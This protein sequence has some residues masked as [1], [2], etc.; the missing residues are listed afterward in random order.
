MDWRKI[1]SLA[2]LRAF[3]AVA[4]HRSYSAA[5]RELNVTEAAVRQH[6]RGLEDFF[7]LSLVHRSGRGIALSDPGQ[8]L[9][10]SVA[11]GFQTLLSGIEDLQRDDALRPLKIALTPAFAENWLMPRLGRFWAEHP[12]IETELAPSL[13]LV[14]LKSDGVDL[15]IRYGH[16]S[17]PGTRAELLASAEYLV[18]AT[19]D[20]MAGRTAAS[21]AELR[22]LPWL[23]EDSRR[24]HQA[25]AAER[26]IDF[27]AAQN[28]FYP[29]NSLVLSAVRAGYG[30]SLQARALV[31]RDLQAGTLIQVFSEDPGTLGYYMVTLPEPRAKLRVLLK[32]L[33]AAA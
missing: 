20:F 13:R 9:A 3:E 26:G 25:W 10:A 12:E 16:G 29:T 33:K 31:E 14:D 27:H 23:F 24:E 22:D 2:G 21:L 32:W 6:L 28:R 15:A 1:P 8:K 19:A 11:S 17:W 30:L 4:R 7:G 5:A 18:V